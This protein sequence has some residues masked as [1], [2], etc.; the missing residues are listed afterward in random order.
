MCKILTTILLL[1]AV[2]GAAT[3]DEIRPGYLELSTTDGNAY[4]VKWKVP[5]LGD[6]VLSLKPVLP[7]SCTIIISNR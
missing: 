7:D 6:K 4:S 3:A 5:M 1:L 2:S